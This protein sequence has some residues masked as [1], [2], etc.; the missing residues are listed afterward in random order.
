MKIVILIA[1]T[2]GLLAG[3]FFIFT[4]KNESDLTK[5]EAKGKRIL[6]SKNP[7]LLKEEK[8][9][10]KKL[11]EI[12]VENKKKEEEIERS[13]KRRKSK[14]ELS[15]SKKA[16]S[17]ETLNKMKEEDTQFKK[18]LIGQERKTESYFKEPEISFNEGQYLVSE[19]LKAIRKKDYKGDPKN[20]VQEM[21]PFLVIN[22]DGE[23]LK[24]DIS[25]KLMVFDKK[26]RQLGIVSGRFKVNLKEESSLEEF[27]KRQGLKTLFK[28]KE[29]NFYYLKTVEK[30]TNP[31]GK[32]SEIKKDDSVTKVEFEILETFNKSK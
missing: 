29:K 21:G 26:D 7:S 25:G 6:S 4:E 31:Q 1:L 13:Q 11:K 9:L 18:R 10:T 20:I 22:T 30:L 12:E 8:E 15:N 19:K 16:I 32:L 3:G 14:E 2:V 28:N 24:N 23:D 17:Q 5:K 27:E